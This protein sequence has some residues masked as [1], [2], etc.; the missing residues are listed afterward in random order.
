MLLFKFVRTTDAH[1]AKPG[2]HDRKYNTVRSA[3]LDNIPRRVWDHQFQ[4]SVKTLWDKMRTMMCQRRKQNREKISAP[5]ITEEV[6]DFQRLLDELIVEKD[7]FELCQ[8]QEREIANT[9]EQK[10]LE[11]GEVV[12]RMA[13]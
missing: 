3:F 2:D 12:Q 9:R 11:A 6:T 1:R 5:D 8:V 13:L 10:V 7:D 4:P